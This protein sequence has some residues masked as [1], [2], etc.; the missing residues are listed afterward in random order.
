MEFIKSLVEFAQMN[1]DNVVFGA[2]LLF[3]LVR[4]YF[5]SQHFDVVERDI[6]RALQRADKAHDRVDKYLDCKR[7]T[8]RE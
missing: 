4:Q 6:N 1:P 3:V 2:L 5:Q 8:T 7:A